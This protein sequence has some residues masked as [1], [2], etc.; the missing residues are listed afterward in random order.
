MKTK[1]IDKLMVP[2]PLNYKSQW[3]PRTTG[4]HKGG[5]F[6]VE[7]DEEISSW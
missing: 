4:S 7:A 6:N 3:N 2:L 1:S 5:V